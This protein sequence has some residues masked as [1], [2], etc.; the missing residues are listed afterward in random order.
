MNEGSGGCEVLTRR[1][2]WME[3]ARD[4]SV[5]LL[6]GGATV[7]TSL[8]VANL[9]LTM[10]AFLVLWALFVAIFTSISVIDSRY[11]SHGSVKASLASSAVF[12]SYMV[13][14]ACTTR[15]P[16]HP[17]SL[18]WWISIGFA[19]MALTLGYVGRLYFG[20]GAEEMRG[21][22]ASSVGVGES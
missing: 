13:L 11:G 9:E 6:I 8:L 3:L 21:A 12:A 16:A 19:L 18:F 5:G 22:A 2:M 14:A 20:Q 1:A 15:W 10:Q 4:L 7:F 17:N